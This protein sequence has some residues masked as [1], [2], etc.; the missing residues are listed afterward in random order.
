MTL[1]PQVRAV[2]A[3][4][5]AAFLTTSPFSIGVLLQAKWVSNWAASPANLYILWAISFVVS[6]LA[7]LLVYRRY[8]PQPTEHAA[9]LAEL[10]LIAE[11]L[12]RATW[13]AVFPPLLVAATLWWI[14]TYG[15][16]L[17]WRYAAD[18]PLENNPL[19]RKMVT[20][21]VLVCGVTTWIAGGGLA[22]WFGMSRAYQFRRTLLLGTVL[23]QWLGLT[24]IADAMLWDTFRVP[25]A[26]AATAH[27]L[28]ASALCV[29]VWQAIR[30]NRLERLDRSPG[31]F[32]FDSRDPAY[33]G[34]RG[35]NL[36]SIWFQALAASGVALALI[37]A[38]LLRWSHF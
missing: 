20:H 1:T 14:T 2:G 4:L 36:A 7:Y 10:S 32:Y 17:P 13:L 38:L 11:P 15:S 27:A 37:A 6:S 18:G 23:N 8:A 21:A 19:Y 3:M 34:P 28:K 26:A 30:L 25:V 16:E 24:W 9:P 5:A 33:R 22:A 29:I 31:A 35:T 12:P